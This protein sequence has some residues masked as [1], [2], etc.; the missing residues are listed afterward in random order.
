MMVGMNPLVDSIP[1][2]ARK[3]VYGLVLLASLVF[4]AWQAAQGNVEVFVGFLIT[5]LVN[6]LAL[7]NT[8]ASRAEVEEAAE[9]L[10]EENPEQYLDGHAE[11]PLF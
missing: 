5:A 7:S 10:V 3:Y 6:G 1:P 2:R 11:R 9:E 8:P 4:G